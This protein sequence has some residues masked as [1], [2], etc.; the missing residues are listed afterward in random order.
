MNYLMLDHFLLHLNETF[1]STYND[2]EL[3][4]V[5]TEAKPLG[6]PTASRQPFSLLFLCEMPEIMPQSIYVLRHHAMGELGVFLV[7]IDR[8]AKGVLYQAVFN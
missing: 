5:L 6:H 1:A 8:H 4:F 2:K 3:S 7:P